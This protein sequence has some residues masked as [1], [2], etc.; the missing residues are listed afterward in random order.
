VASFRTRPF[1]TGFYKWRHS[2][3]G[4]LVEVLD[5][6]NFLGKHGYYSTV[7]VRGTRQ[8]QDSTKVWSADLFR[9]NF[10]PVGRKKKAK[11]ALDRVLENSAK[12]DP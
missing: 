4:Y 10:E 12:D 6:R 1:E 8:R 9:A 3:Q 2:T 11:S 5:V 7:L